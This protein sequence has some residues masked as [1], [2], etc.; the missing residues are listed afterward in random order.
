[1]RAANVSSFAAMF[2]PRIAKRVSP[3]QIKFPQ[4]FIFQFPIIEVPSQKVNSCKKWAFRAVCTAFL[5]LSIDFFRAGCY[6]DSD[7]YFS[8]IQNQNCSKKPFTKERGLKL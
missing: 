1:M 3:P 6:T 5:P 7:K 4:I 8:K 2:S